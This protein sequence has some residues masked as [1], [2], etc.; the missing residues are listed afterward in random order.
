MRWLAHL[1]VRG[2]GAPFVLGDLEEGW[3]RDLQRGLS[4]RRARWRY[5][6]NAA[7]SAVS[8]GRA[9][10][11]VPPLRL[12]ATG[13][14]W[15]DVKLG[16][17]MMVKYPGLTA[18]AVF[19]LALGIP[20]S[21]APDYLLSLFDVT[22]PFEDGE[23]L[24]G[25]RH[26]LAAV[27]EESPGTAHEY[28][29]WRETLTGLDAIGAAR[30]D[31]YNV[32]A[33][34][35]R[36][37]PYRGSLAT[38]S[39]FAILRVAPVLGRP[40]VE[41]DEAT[42]APD[43]VVIGAELWRSFFDADPAV[44]GRTLRIGG[45]PHM[46]V[47]VMPEGFLFPQNDHFWLPL[48]TGPIA[49]APGEGPSLWI[50]GR[51]AAGVSEAQVQAQMTVVQ[52]GLAEA[53][54]EAYG[55][56]RPETV[57]L[58]NLLIGNPTSAQLRWLMAPFRLV[59]LLMLA[60]VCGNVGTLVLARTATRTGEV[61]VR[62]ALGASRARIVSQLFVESLVLALLATGVG[63]V[64]AELVLARVSR[65]DGFADL[66]FWTD[67][68]LRR[69][70]VARA[71]GLAVFSSVIAGVLPAL[72]ATG[73]GIQGT[74]Q[75]A[76]AGRSGI[77]FGSVTTGLIVAEVALGVTC[78]FAMAVCYRLIP[79]DHSAAM[80][81]RTD[82]FLSAVLNVSRQTTAGGARETDPESWRRHVASVQ[83]DLGQR[84]SMEPSVRGVALANT[85]PGQ[86][87]REGRVEVEGA[88][89]VPGGRGRVLSARVAVGFFEE[90]GQPVLEGRSFREDDV[91]VDG[92]AARLPII[93]NTAFVDRVLGGRNPIGQRVRY[94]PTGDDEPDPWYEIVG[95]VGHL[96]M[97]G[98]E[99]LRD[100]AG[101]YHPASP[102]TMNPVRMAIRVIGDPV[103]FGRRLREIA[104]EVDPAAMIEEP[105]RL[106]RMVDPDLL[107]SRTIMVALGVVGAIAV[108][109]SVA[110]LYALMSFTVAQRTRE[111]GIRSALGA[112]PARIISVIARRALV[113]LTA[114]V[115]VGAVGMV[116]VMRV[117]AD[118]SLTL[119]G[120]LVDSACAVG[121]VVVVG[122]VSCM[123]PTLRGLR[124]RPTEAL[125]L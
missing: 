96:G 91:R 84:L 49:H 3:R 12:F 95:V 99:G 66:P 50:Y 74:L 72:K 73:R 6:R 39:T 22:L 92:Q 7:G 94:V 16:V 85:L 120:W 88:A 117:L 19:A 108:V 17:R 45:T 124:I 112:H 75:R 2:P 93:V 32:I 106:D 29:V 28:A 78:L 41:A 30:S 100:D 68:G 8:L 1:L 83:Q 10:P 9:R 5:V 35:G 111:I 34:D 87:H 121:A 64:L 113:Q 54:P 63:L 118:D 56:L 61:A 60:V 71:L 122:V 21:L 65:L 81:I 58:P 36:A 46:V 37:Q 42:G 44:V 38:A 4:A 15:V 70:T 59:A 27:L 26:R 102:G 24:V 86:P 55:K 115:L 76:A 104:A 57:A 101:L 23:R 90:L 119:R 48:R 52:R 18:V 114:G 20:A 31:R 107:G 33:E 51:L 40:L 25:L 103:A 123:A 43:V 69:G 105:M 82:R 116:A 14:S 98:L 11:R 97:N 79:P 53:F 67:F 80:S 110:G 47:G 109:L 62:T 13:A 77:R 89:D 125:R